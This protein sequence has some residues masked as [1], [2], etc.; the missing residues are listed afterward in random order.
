MSIQ[1]WFVGNVVEEHAQSLNPIEHLWDEL[2]SQTSVPDLTN[3]LVAEWKQV[4]T[5][6][7]QHVVEGLPRRVE[8]VI[9][10][11]GVQFPE[12]LF[13]SSHTLPRRIQPGSQFPEEWRLFRSSHTLPRRIHPGSQFP[14]E[15]RL[16]RSSHT[17]PRRIH[18]GT[19][20]PEEWRLFRSSHTPPGSLSGFCFSFG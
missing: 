18:P 8:A 13:R 20:F 10:A 9:A 11:K 16:F 19:Q 4:P 3:A 12:V 5:A 6:M 15:W 1:K 2:E 7:F 14:E 17:L